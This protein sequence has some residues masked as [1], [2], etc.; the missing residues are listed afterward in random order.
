MRIDVIGAG[1]FGCTAAIHLKREGYEVE[2]YERSDDILTGA[3]GHNQFR[4]HRGY[5]YP[6]SPQT[7]R[8]CRA[9]N[10]SF[11][12]EYGNAVIRPSRRNQQVYAIARENSKTAA[13]GFDHFCRDEGL[14]ARITEVREPML[15]PETVDMAWN[16][17]ESRVDI[18]RLKTIVQ[19]KLDELEIPV[20]FGKEVKRGT[21]GENVVNVYATYKPPANPQATYRFQV[22]EKPVLRFPDIWQDLSVVVMDGPFCC[23]DPLGASGFSVMGHVTKSIHW[24]GTV[25]PPAWFPKLNQGIVRLDDSLWPE[26]REDAIRYMPFVEKADY[27][28]SFLTMRCVMDDPD[29]ARPTEVT[30]E[31]ERQYRIF[32]GKLGTCVDAARQVVRKVRRDHAP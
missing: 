14:P 19:G 23:V 29:D 1:I 24:A 32:S 18:V 28:G 31:G 16:V 20:H 13:G 2:V 5:H 10:E 12:Q 4:L 9:G 25:E 3:T 6:R 22:V 30:E 26:M 11:M 7:G 17:L 8:Q 27:R 21:P 15:N